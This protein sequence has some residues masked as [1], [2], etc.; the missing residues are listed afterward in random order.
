VQNGLLRRDA[1]PKIAGTLGYLD[2]LPFEGLHGA[3]VRSTVARGILRRILYDPAF[4]WSP[5]VIV[6]PADIPGENVCPGLMEDQPFLSGGEIRFYGEPLALIACADLPLLRDAL[7]HIRIEA[8]PL[9]PL[10]SLEAASS[11]AITVFGNDNSFKTIE[12][13]KGDTQAVF[14]DPAQRLFEGLYETAGQEHLYLEPQGMEALYREGVIVVKGSMQCPGYVAGA[15]KRLSGETVEIE[16]TPTGGGFGGKEDY[17]SLIAG[18]VWLLARKSG[19]NVRI[20]YGRSE[21]MAYTTKRHPARISYRTAIDPN[22]KIA[23]M[24]VNFEIDAGA[25]CTLSPVVLSRGAL[26]ACGLYDFSSVSLLARAL[27]TNTP[28]SGAFRGFGAPQAIFA[29]ERHM[30]D[31]ARWIGEDPLDFRRRHLPGAGST[32]LTG[33]PIREADAL[34]DL[35]ERAASESDYT[36]RRDA[37]SVGTTPLRGIGMA[38]FMHGGGFTGSGESFLASRVRLEAGESG[39]VTIRIIS[40]EIGQGASTVLPAL[41]AQELGI[42]AELID[43]ALP[44]TATGSDSGPTVAS[45]TTMVIGDLLCRAAR[46]LREALNFYADDE[47]FR[48]ALKHHL[49]RGGE[50]VFE[51]VFSPPGDIVWDEEHYRGD[52]YLGYS[53]GCT[54]AEVQ[55]DP[56]SYRVRVMELYALSDIGRVVNPLLAQGQVYG[57]MVQAMGYALT[58]ELIYRDGR[59]LNPRLCDYMIPVAADVPPMRA[60]FVQSDE[61][62]KGLG[63]LPMDGAGA[64]IANAVADALGMRITKL[65]ITPQ[66]ILEALR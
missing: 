43:Y 56:I 10:L 35:L 29:L 60:V 36:R 14:S 62:P 18:Y 17:P 38:L 63:E 40:T 37:L 9:E 59:L 16:Q 22:G 6:E 49:K 4:D 8:D 47:A 54:V 42:S 31:L 23:A 30:D 44:N 25:Y 1:W 24:E 48:T 46:K 2:D 32:T 64:A 55:I 58:E 66:T 50:R 19:R 7:K 57:G 13:T 41:V 61:K 28:P 12:I 5:F 45:R 11:N 26:H 65:P 53:L 15:L 51:S 20:V 3:I 34:R 27:A 33:A 39:R 21:D 52:A